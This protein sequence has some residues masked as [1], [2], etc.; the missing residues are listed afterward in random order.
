M[1]KENQVKKNVSSHGKPGAA[2]P[3]TSNTVLLTIATCILLFGTLLVVGAVSQAIDRSN[4]EK[5]AD[6]TRATQLKEQEES[7]RKAQQDKICTNPK[8]YSPGYVQETPT[9][10]VK[11]VSVEDKVKTTVTAAT[12]QTLQSSSDEKWI[13]VL[14]S[15]SNKT[16]T[17]LDMSS[18]SLSYSFPEFL[19]DDTIHNSLSDAVEPDSSFTEG[20]TSIVGDLAPYEV[21]TV[22]YLVKPIGAIGMRVGSSAGYGSCFTGW[23]IR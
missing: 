14:Y 11:I 6:A 2:A 13:R 16:G 17:R 5:A 21:A 12:D 4:K 18:S 20:T 19:I 9:L 22:A 3:S 8:F 15:V 23:K 7:M 10:A 1:A